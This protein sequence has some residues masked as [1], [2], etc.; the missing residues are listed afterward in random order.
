[1]RIA[2]IMF[3]PRRQHE[4]KFAGG[5]T[6]EV[7]FHNPLA[8]RLPQMPSPLVNTHELTSSYEGRLR[9]MERRK[10]YNR[11]YMEQK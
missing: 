11:I 4:M 5:E 7:R 6:W 8:R 3:K 10:K 2:E 9:T 1:M